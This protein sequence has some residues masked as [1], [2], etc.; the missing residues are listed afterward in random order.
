ML[1]RVRLKEVI[2]LWTRSQEKQDESGSSQVVPSTNVE[3]LSL[4]CICVSVHAGCLSCSV[5]H[6]LHNTPGTSQK[7]GTPAPWLKFEIF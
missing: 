1:V 3:A 4:N 2:G 6:Y 7:E 5:D